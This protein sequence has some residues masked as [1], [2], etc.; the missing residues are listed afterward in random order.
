MDTAEEISTQHG[1]IKALQME[2]DELQGDNTELIRIVY[3]D[4][5]GDSRLFCE[6]FTYGEVSEIC[7]LLGFDK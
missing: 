5:V 1:K 3:T 2:V 4:P 7:R 6:V